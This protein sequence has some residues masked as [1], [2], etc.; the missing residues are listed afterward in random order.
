MAILNGSIGPIDKTMT[1]FNQFYKYDNYIY[2]SSRIKYHIGAAEGNKFIEFT[3]STNYNIKT[4]MTT[5]SEIFS[6]P[7]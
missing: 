7:K 5:F 2:V 1:G 3:F 4:G 6:I